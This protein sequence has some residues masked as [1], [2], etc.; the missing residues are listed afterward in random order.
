[1][2]RD[3]IIAANPIG[4]WLESRGVKLVQGGKRGARCPA[5]EHTRTGNVSVDHDKNLWN[6]HACTYRVEVEH[7]TPPVQHL[8]PSP[9]S[10]AN[11][12]RLLVTSGIQ[13]GLKPPVE[14]VIEVNAEPVQPPKLTEGEQKH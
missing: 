1:M 9:E 6:C 13:H 12:M 3:E 2:T 8:P 5:K 7:H 10:M 4:A 11:V 14:K